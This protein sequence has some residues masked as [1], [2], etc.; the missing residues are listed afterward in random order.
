MVK[1]DT[2]AWSTRIV[3]G[4]RLEARL[5]DT[6]LGTRWLAWGGRDVLPRVAHH[7]SSRV[8]RGVDA[9]AV[10]EPLTR[11]V[12]AHA[13]GLEEVVID[14]G[15]TW[16]LAPYCGS[17]DGLMPLARLMSMKREGCLAARES[18]FLGLHLLGAIDAGWRRGLGHGPL[19]IDDVLIDRRG[20]AMIELFGVEARC[21]GEDPLAAAHAS[22]AGVVGLVYELA[23]GMAPGSRGASAAMGRSLPRGLESFFHRGLSRDDGFASPAEAMS[24]LNTAVV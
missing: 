5:G 15:E 23:T 3:G 21:R 24:A 11:F 20:R 10:L 17:Y 22:V 7:L 2:A 18:V 14:R 6:R 9:L 13:V 1:G 8:A 16:L 4:W 19:G 12:H